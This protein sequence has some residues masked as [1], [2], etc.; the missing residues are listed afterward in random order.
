MKGK[1]ELPTS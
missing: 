1:L